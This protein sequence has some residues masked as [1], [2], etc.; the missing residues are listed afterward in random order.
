MYKRQSLT[1]QLFSLDADWAK[2]NNIDWLSYRNFSAHLVERSNEW[3]EKYL[4]LGT[5]ENNVFDE[6][7]KVITT[8]DKLADESIQQTERIFEFKEAYVN[9]RNWGKVKIKSVKY[10]NREIHEQKFITLDAQNI[11]KAILKDALSGEIILFFK[12]K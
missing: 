2:A 4:P 9:T 3:G 6:K 11:T 12:E 5:I 10:I 1:Q 7:G 8:L